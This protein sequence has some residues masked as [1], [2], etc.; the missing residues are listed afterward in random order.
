M[1]T[2]GDKPRLYQEPLE[3]SALETLW[4]ED[5]NPMDWHMI[6]QPVDKS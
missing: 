2:P 6:R 1:S 5:E 4:D 3:E